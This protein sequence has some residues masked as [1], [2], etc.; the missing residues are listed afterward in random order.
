MEPVLGIREAIKS[1]SDLEMSR[2]VRNFNQ[3][4]S[5]WTSQLTIL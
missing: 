4:L 2:P 3:D 5:F 1:F